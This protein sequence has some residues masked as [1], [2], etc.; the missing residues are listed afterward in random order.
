MT[1]GQEGRTCGGGG[2]GGRGFGDFE[3]DP[4]LASCCEKEEKMY[5][6]AL[7]KLK[8]LR[9]SG[10][11]ADARQREAWRGG[12]DLLP[13]PPPP[14]PPPLR[15]VSS[16]G[17]DIHGTNDDDDDEDDAW[18]DEDEEDELI[19]QMRDMRMAQMKL[20]HHKAAAA[21]R[22]T[23]QA[24]HERGPVVERITSVDEMRHKS[25]ELIKETNV[26]GRKGRN[27]RNAPA[28]L[29]HWS[30]RGCEDGA[31]MDQ[32]LEDMATALALQ[33]CNGST[34]TANSSIPPMKLLSCVCERRVR[35]P[36]ALGSST[37]APAILAVRGG[38]IVARA[39]GYTAFGGG[40]GGGDICE[41]SV[42]AWLRASHIL[43]KRPEDRGSARG[44]EEDDDD[45]Y[46]D[47]DDSENE[48]APCAQ[49]GRTYPHEHVRAVYNSSSTTSGLWDTADDDDDDDDD[50]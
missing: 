22:R 18:W 8:I 20:Q 24:I 36:P 13:P 19:A 44:G 35:L 5:K 28:Y 30:L 46:D 11:E 14:P 48:C 3:T 25:S 16:N 34:G 33:S 50:V 49:C 37:L 40:E 6:K 4:T 32:V 21:A 45:E 47:D 10:P 17:N 23:Q 39:E 9:A 1:N 41:E 27:G 31:A 2:G 15:S 29:C 43:P 38:V 26:Y 7:E 12:G 42:E